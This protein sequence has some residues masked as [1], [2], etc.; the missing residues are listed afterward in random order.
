MKI[1]VAGT[2]MIGHLNPL[3][4]I[5]RFLV[6]DGHEVVAHSASAHRARLRASGARFHPFSRAI[7]QDLSDLDAVYPQLKA[8]PPGPAKLSFLFRHAFIDRLGGQH[9][10]LRR[11][12]RRFP[13][14]LVLCDNLFLGTA[15]LLLGPPERR[16]AIVH[17]GVTPLFTSRDDGAPQGPGLA[18]AADDAQREAYRAISR[19]ADQHFFEPIQAEL[20]RTLAAIGLG[21]LP[22]RMNDASVRLPDL[23]LQP[24]VSGFEFPRREVPRALRFIGALP[25]P[26]GDL[27]LPEWAHE[28]DAAARVVLVTQ[29]TLANHDL[30]Q[31]IGP[32]LAALGDR[33]DLLVLV[34][35]GGRPLQAVPGP[36]PRHVR[37][38][39]FLPY[40]WLMPRLDLVVTNG[41]YGTV[42]H[43][44][45]HGV[46]LVVAGLS[47]DKAE[48]GARVAWSGAG[49]SLHTDTPTPAAL[50]AAIDTVLG[51]ERFGAAARGLAGAF[52]GFDAATE[53]PR[54]LR[55]VV[56]AR[57]AGPGAGQGAGQPAPRGAGRGA[58]RE[59]SEARPGAATSR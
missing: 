50:R 3:L 5:A 15:P 47:E 24:T 8:L 27:S 52:R 34:T 22:C 20:D 53:V 59:A 37:L 31:L 19:A 44:L 49:V 35:T 26:P 11:L 38:A 54:L 21:P 58:A 4:S 51:G 29:G 42:N 40:D 39:R 14:D 57:G 1:I 46:P 36:I 33:P 7:D 55:E 18:L 16:P 43:A 48:V 30:A 6:A 23:F 12:M 45:S 28:V 41:G 13:A 2:P 56:A 25:L 32:T 10:S 17:L 9:E